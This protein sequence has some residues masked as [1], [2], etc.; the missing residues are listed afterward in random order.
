MQLSFIY[1]HICVSFRR[2]S[3]LDF[4]YQCGLEVCTIPKED[5]NGHKQEGS[6]LVKAFS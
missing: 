4:S 6:E 3:L 1:I 5:V 2:M